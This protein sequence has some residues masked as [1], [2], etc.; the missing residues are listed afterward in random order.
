MKAL[1]QNKLHNLLVANLS[2]HQKNEKF[3]N[4]LHNVDGVPTIYIYDVISS[5][6]YWGF[7]ATQFA[8]LLNEAGDAEV[9]NVRIDSPGGEV[10]AANSMYALLSQNRAAVNVYIDGLCASAATY[11]PLAASHVVASKG[12][13]I[14]IHNSMVCACGN[15]SDL[16]QAAQT[17]EK[18]DESIADLYATHT[19][20]DKEEIIAWMNAETWFNTDDA[21]K[22]NFINEI[23]SGKESQ[24]NR[25]ESWAI[26]NIFK[27]IPGPLM[28]KSVEPTERQPRIDT[29]KFSNTLRAKKAELL[30]RHI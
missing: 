10:F 25:S 2:R 24:S 4:A 8:Q 29:Q 17:L 22:H 11:L 5:D 30:A 27:N 9:I 7:T 28:K 14:M 1:F 3:C 23:W 26:Q 6:D 21:L 16:T 18:L 12:A 20:Q 19:G 13:F 15:K